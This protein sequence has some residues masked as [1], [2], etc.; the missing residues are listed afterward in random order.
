MDISLTLGATSS[1]VEVMGTAPLLNM[2]SATL[3]QVIEDRLI[4]SVPNSGRNPLSLVALAP[5]IVGSTGGVSF[6]SN[7][8]RNNSAE[9]L[10]DGAAL[11]SHRAERR[12]HGRQVHPDV[13]RGG[14][15]SRCRPTSSARSSGTPA[16][17]SST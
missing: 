4:Q 12:H 11:T 5:G 1:S 10:M 17:P 15:S 9:V 6:V 2:T 3:G 7:G 14:G 8:V 16:A 13:G